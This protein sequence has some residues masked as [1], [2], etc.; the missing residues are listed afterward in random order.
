MIT[1]ICILNFTQLSTNFQLN[2]L[3]ILRDIRLTIANKICKEPLGISF[4]EPLFSQYRRDSMST[5][6]YRVSM[7]HFFIFWRS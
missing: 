4:M 5:F 7:L 1:V 2:L 6:F 3:I